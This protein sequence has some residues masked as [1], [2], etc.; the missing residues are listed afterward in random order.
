ML[1]DG[2]ASLGT[3]RDNIHNARR[4]ITIA[5]KF[6][7]PQRRKRRGLRGFQHASVAACKRRRQ[8]P[9]GHHQRKV[10]RNNLS[11]HANWSG[12]MSTSNRVAQLVAPAR[13]VEKMFRR[14]R[15]IRVA[16]FLN[17]FA[18][19]E[20][21]QHGK[22]ARAFLQ[23]SRHTKQQLAA[24]AGLHARPTTQRLA[25]RLVRAVHIALASLRHAGQVFLSRG[26]DHIHGAPAFGRHKLA[27]YI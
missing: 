14:F 19:V 20:R 1:R 12:L 26:I 22:F 27:I 6:R 3:T 5:K 18:V 8:F 7:Q 2:F 21:L 10:P 25:R 13:V 11:A 24:L 4:K 23:L 17:G 9:R 15:N 16:T